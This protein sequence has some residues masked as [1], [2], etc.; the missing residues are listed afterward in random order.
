MEHERRRDGCCRKRKRAVEIERKR[1][2]VS[3]GEPAWHASAT[4]PPSPP[5]LAA[6]ARVVR[7]S[8]FNRG[9]NASEV[10]ACGGAS[11]LRRVRDRRRI[12]VCAAPCPS[13]RRC[14]GSTKRLLIGSPPRSVGRRRASHAAAAATAA[15][16]RRLGRLT[17]H[18]D[19]H[20]SCA[21]EPSYPAA[22]IAALCVLRT[23][24]SARV[25]E[26]DFVRRCSFPARRQLLW[27]SCLRAFGTFFIAA[28]VSLGFQ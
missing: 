10:Y 16:P 19:S 5:L 14:S 13:D 15:Q 25:G 3:E 11:G 7:W 1:V 23:V 24:V 17:V 28:L 22:V 2:L 9:A 27:S 26:T 4:T 20:R 18:A 8:V 6:D 12:R 21:D